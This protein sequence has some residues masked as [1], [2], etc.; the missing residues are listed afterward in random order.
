MLQDGLPVL[1]G[2]GNPDRGISQPIKKSRSPGDSFSKVS[3]GNAFI[4]FLN[5][6]FTILQPGCFVQAR[7]MVFKGDK[8]VHGSRGSRF[9]V[10]EVQGSRFV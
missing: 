10:Q 1:A 7:I 4:K 3:I 9:K 8:E 5:I 6:P 2:P